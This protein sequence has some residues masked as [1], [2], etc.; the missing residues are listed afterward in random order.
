MDKIKQWVLDR[1][2]IQKELNSSMNTF[3]KFREETYVK[4]FMDARKDIL[5][6]MVDDI[7]KKAKQLSDKRL[8]EMLSI[9]D[10]N[11]II[12]IGLKDRCFYLGKEKATDAQINNL[13]AEAEFLLNSH[14]WKLLNETPKELAHK[15][16]FVTS[17]SLVDLQKGKSMLFLLDTQNKII[18]MLKQYTP[19]K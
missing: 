1:Q 9:I 8:N 12:S 7:D 3:I 4:A 10:V 16:M 18:E 13:K 15:T 14:I 17:E 2:F 11:N 6:T 5:E 19:K